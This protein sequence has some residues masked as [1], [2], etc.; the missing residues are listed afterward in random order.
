MRYRFARVALMALGLCVAACDY[1][2]WQDDGTVSIAILS[3]HTGVEEIAK[4]ME[5]VFS[6]AVDDVNS[7]GGI[8][9]R[10]LV[11]VVR[12]TTSNPAGAV[13]EYMAAITDDRV[14]AF[15]GPALSGEV[16]AL[17]PVAKVSQVPFISPSS[18]DPTLS[19]VTEDDGFMF[20]NVADDGLQGVAD[21]QYL[22]RL[23]SPTVTNAA[24]V[25]EDTGYGAGLK[26]T[27]TK[28]FTG[29]GGTVVTTIK[30]TPKT[31]DAKAIMAAL[32]SANPPPTVTLLIAIENDPGTITG[33]WA[34]SGSLP[35]MEWFMTDGAH[36]ASFLSG[37]PA[38]LLGQC[39][40]A[41][42]FPTNGL[43]FAALR[44]AYESRNMDKLED[45]A[46]APYVWDAVQLTAMAMVVQVHAHPDEP[47]GGAH[48][49]DAIL[50]TSKNGQ[51][52]RSDQWRDMVYAVR[53]NRDI[54]YDGAS[55]PDDFD[56]FGQAIGPYEVW[57]LTKAGGAT[58]FSFGQQTYLD[59]DGI[60]A[61]IEELRSKAARP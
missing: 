13:R 49:R 16:K 36:S 55:G 10:Q 48:L 3:P 61:V 32:A 46:F 52:F 41:P 51:V 34:S 47:I 7:R 23:R 56:D 27:F 6:A 39:G 20:R 14:A 24:V 60:Q 1:D 53:G 44:E 28:A 59:T 2:Q 43:A 15:V 54:D 35:S 19:A 50:T 18:T 29:L 58:T 31:P 57:C 17:Y 4:S 21:A 40:T 42:T 26:D 45:Q 25:Y 11:P 8:E 9:G 12:D 5:R 37:A 33:E 38:K 30:F 22:R